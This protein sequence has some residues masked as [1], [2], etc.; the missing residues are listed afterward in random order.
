MEWQ[1]A[2]VIYGEVCRAGSACTLCNRNDNRLDRYSGREIRVR[3]HTFIGWPICWV[4]WHPEDIPE[5]YSKDAPFGICR[6]YLL[7]D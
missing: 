6:H 5:E 7:M 1:P 4:Q 2:I 3:E